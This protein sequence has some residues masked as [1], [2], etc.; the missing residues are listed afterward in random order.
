MAKVSKVTVKAVI[1]IDGKV[2]LLRKNSNAWD[3]PGGGISRGETAE[4][5]LLREVYEETNLKVEIDR[6]L[7]AFFIINRHG[8]TNFCTTYLCRPIG[9]VDLRID[10]EHSEYLFADPDHLPVD[11]LPMQYADSIGIAWGKSPQDL[12]PRPLKVIEDDL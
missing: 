5:A 11:E 10:T 4:Q 6:P 1:E 8:K 7:R 2:A 12:P 9:E 3:L